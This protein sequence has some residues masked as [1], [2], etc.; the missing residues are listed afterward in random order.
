[1]EEEVI[2]NAD[3]VAQLIYE[4]T[5]TLLSLKSGTI[6]SASISAKGVTPKVGEYT[7]KIKVESDID[8]TTVEEL[9]IESGLPI[10]DD[11]F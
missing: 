10:T 6:L 5:G 3:Q 2:F 4:T 1:M 7:F 9:K 8:T 11:T